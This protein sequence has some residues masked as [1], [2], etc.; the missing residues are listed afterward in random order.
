MSWLKNM[1][2][3]AKTALLGIIPLIALIALSTINAFNSANT[4]EQFKDVAE[5]VTV[6]AI[7]ISTYTAHL[8]ATQKDILKSITTDDPAELKEVNEDFAG[9]RH[10]M[11][12]IIE[13]YE[14][15]PLDD[16]EKTMWAKVEAL[17]HKL[18][19]VQDNCLKLGM[20]DKNAE[21]AE[22]FFEAVDPVAT[23]LNGNLADLRAYL[24]EKADRREREVVEEA[25]RQSV[26]AI[27]IS[28]VV[29][30]IVILLVIVVSRMI[31]R[32]IAVMQEKI[33]RF[34]N[35]ELGVDFKDDGKD[36]ISK[37]SD[38]LAHMTDA[39]NT[40]LGGVLDVCDQI[41]DAAQDSSSIS[42][43]C[44]ASVEELRANINEMGQNLSALSSTS[45]E[46]TASVEEVAAGAQTTAEKG[47]EIARKVD[48]AMRAGDEGVKAVNSVVSA[49]GRV[50]SSSSASSAAVLEL[51]NR[52]RQIQGFVSQIGSIADQTNLLALNAAIE[53]ARA[54]DAGRGFAVVAEEV[55]KLAEDSNVAAKNI[56]EL[57]ATITSELD[58]IV[59]YSQENEN[60]SNEAKQLSSETSSAI[61]NMIGYLR[62]IA[63]A[64]QDLAAVAEEQAAS[65][66][67]IAEAVQS[68][69]TK[70]NDTTTA[71]EGVNTAVGD[72]ATAS[73]Q[74]ASDAEALAGLSN[75]LKE[76]LK[77]FK[78]A[79]GT[80]SRSRRPAA[81]KTIAKPK[82]IPGRTGTG[83]R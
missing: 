47:T 42:E 33:G 11:N 64:T 4:S 72:V 19:E 31:V 15:M 69:S 50:A 18:R 61:E 27:T 67:E 12:E 28:A 41:A 2:V 65:S 17:R 73:E 52:A 78:L 32:P 71:G 53:A 39:L 55:R 38:A 59:K 14:A 26:T 60:D 23:D 45:E 25:H 7:Q 21:A 76:D 24:T 56:A 63:A 46:V 20:E 70:I 29:T 6:S 5:N 48:D 51:G 77:F 13:K 1:R 10:S 30:V 40:T 81:K 80:N 9:R 82:A 66:E 37:M 44:N 43:E 54:G 16:T 83:R 35:G 57:A 34:A 8:Q 75:D 58:T 22:Y 79:D 3:S 49:S 74:V 62:D 36:E 68:M